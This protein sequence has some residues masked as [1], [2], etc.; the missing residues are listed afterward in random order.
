MRSRPIVIEYEG[1]LEN[2]LDSLVDHPMVLFRPWLQLLLL[3]MIL[4]HLKMED[5]GQS[6]L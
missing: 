3:S 1:Y 6:L 5:D 4:P 2:A